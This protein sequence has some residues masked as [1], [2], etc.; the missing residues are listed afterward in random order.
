[1]TT[2]Y[3]VTPSVT[4]SGSV[5]A[6]SQSIGNIRN[7]FIA[8]GFTRTLQ[9]GSV[10]NLSTLSADTTLNIRRTFD[11]FAF[12]DSW[13]V[14]HPLFIYVSY[15][16]GISSS[17]H[18]RIQYAMGTSHDSSGSLTGNSTLT[19]IQDTTS[20]SYAQY[21]NVPVYASGD[22]S[23]M[24]LLSYANLTEM[25]QFAVFERF[26]DQYGQPTGSGFHMIGTNAN[27]GSK[28]IY[29]QACNY[30]Q[31]PPL[32]E[33]INIPCIKPSLGPSVYNGVLLLGQ[34]F[35]FV[36]RPMNPSPNILLGDGIGF[37]TSYELTEYTMY[38]TTRQYIVGPSNLSQTNTIIFPSTRFLLRYT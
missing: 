10:D 33:S 4:T 38:N 23:Y 37:P 29:S 17:G 30:G 11:I 26:Y 28:I 1:M 32:Q 6:Q 27:S 14:T 21:T 36:G 9:S 2:Y 8:C 18:F 24:T 31:T 35:P 5:A 12:N 25:G 7:A 16:T 15:W 20:S 13:Q 3:A 34:I 22:G 19:E